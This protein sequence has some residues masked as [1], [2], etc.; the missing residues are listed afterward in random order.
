MDA[1]SWGF[2]SLE[3]STGDKRPLPADTFEPGQDFKRLC[4]EPCGD[5]IDYNSQ[6]S[7]SFTSL[8]WMDHVENTAES[9]TSTIPVPNLLPPVSSILP[10]QWLA[11]S[12][13]NPISNDT[14]IEQNGMF[15]NQARYSNYQVDSDDFYDT[16]NPN[17]SSVPDL[18]TYYNTWNSDYTG[19]EVPN[20]QM[21]PEWWL[22]GEQSLQCAPSIPYWRI[23]FD[24]C[25][26]NEAN[27][28]PQ[29]N[30]E[31]PQLVTDNDYALQLPLAEVPKPEPST[32][33]WNSPQSSSIAP[34]ATGIEDKSEL[35]KSLGR[36]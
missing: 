27:L 22:S 11:S 35:G 16:H 21:Q 32:S 34:T 19:Q 17:S 25:S 2:D 5:L 4:A 3:P 18:N 12:R 1:K 6:P 24:L 23:P 13:Y 30:I 10:A 29:I 14:L 31:E 28:L 15:L 33:I 20:G 26:G 7:S 8:P 36:A 9:S